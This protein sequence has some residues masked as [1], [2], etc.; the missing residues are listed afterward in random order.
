ME[1]FFYLYCNDDNCFL[2]I[3][4]LFGLLYFYYIFEVYL[5]C[6]CVMLWCIKVFGVGVG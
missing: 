2:I 4:F 1:V 3:N 5:S 6:Y